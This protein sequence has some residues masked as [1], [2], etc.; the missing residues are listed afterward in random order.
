MRVEIAPGD[1]TVERFNRMISSGV[2][3]ASVEEDSLRLTLR[4]ERAFC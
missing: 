3:L 4:P 1:K 2:G